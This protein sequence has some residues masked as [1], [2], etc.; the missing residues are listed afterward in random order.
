MISPQPWAGLQVSKHHYARALAARDW[1]VVFIDP[2]AELGKPGR[3]EQTATEVSGIFRLRYQTFFPYRLKFH[4]RPLFDLLMW[5][6]AKRLVQA[7]GR[8]NLVWDFDNAYQFRDFGPY[9]VYSRLVQPAWRRL[10]RSGWRLTSEDSPRDLHQAIDGKLD[11]RWTTLRP[12][13]PGMA[14]R[15]DLGRLESVRGII[16]KLGASL[17][18]YPRD[19]RVLA[20]ADGESWLEPQTRWSA[21]LYWAGTRLFQMR[22]DQVVYTFPSFP[23]R[24]LKL[25]QR[26]ADPTFYWS[27][28]ELEVIAGQPVSRP[29]QQQGRPSL[30]RRSFRG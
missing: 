15:L 10:D 20:S 28:H 25:E 14:V 3:I 30:P 19:L 4:A 11:T 23:C 2:P 17:R 29:N 8:P 22:G 12:Q 27:I 7:A 1:R 16:L 6:Q 18:D 24:Y 5:R 13:A 21:E 26:G 9:R